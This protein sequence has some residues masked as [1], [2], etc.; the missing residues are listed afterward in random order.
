MLRFGGEVR[1]DRAGNT[2][3]RRTHGGRA[4]DGILGG[5]RRQC[6]ATQQVA[7][8]LEEAATGEV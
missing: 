2:V 4:A 7:A 1:A 6:R 8:L 5:E 3:D